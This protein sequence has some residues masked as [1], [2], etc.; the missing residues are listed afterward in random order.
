[1]GGLHSPASNAHP[2]QLPCPP[3]DGGHLAP[4]AD[5]AAYADIWEPLSAGAHP[6]LGSMLLERQG[7][8]GPAEQARLEKFLKGR[9]AAAAEHFN[10]DQK[11]GVQYLQVGLSPSCGQGRWTWMRG[12]RGL[13]GQCVWWQMRSGSGLASIMRL[14]DLSAWPEMAGFLS[15]AHFHPSA[16]PPVTNHSFSPVPPAVPQAAA[17]GAGAAHGGALPALLP[18]AG[19]GQH[20]GDPGGAGALLRGSQGGLHADL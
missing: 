6:E 18:G 14:P 8:V 5:P 11:K 19:Q 17:A 13:M 4:L 15:Q 20:R 10:R 1:M 12:Q 3:A 2:P 7:Q 16:H 9:L